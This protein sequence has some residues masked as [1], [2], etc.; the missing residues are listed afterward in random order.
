MVNLAF[1]L[2]AVVLFI[3]IS[4]AFRGRF[5]HLSVIRMHKRTASIFNGRTGE[6]DLQCN[7]N[8]SVAVVY[9]L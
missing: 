8:F 6:T 9:S 5:F 3:S 4:P 7:N 2:L 1:T